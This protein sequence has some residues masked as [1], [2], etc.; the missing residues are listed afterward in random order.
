MNLDPE[1]QGL[2]AEGWQFWKKIGIRISDVKRVHSSILHAMHVGLPTPSVTDVQ[3]KMQ[4]LLGKTSAVTKISLEKVKDGG[5]PGALNRSYVYYRENTGIYRLQEIIK[6]LRRIAE[7]MGVALEHVDLTRLEQRWS[8]KRNNSGNACERM[9]RL[10]STDLSGSVRQFE[11]DKVILAIGNGLRAITAHGL[12]FDLKPPVNLFNEFTFFQIRKKYQNG[13]LRPR[14]QGFW[15]W[16]QQG[17]CP[18]MKGGP[19]VSKLGFVAMLENETEDA[20][21]MKVVSDSSY[22]HFAQDVRPAN[23]ERYRAMK[24]YFISQFMQISDEDIDHEDYKVCNYAVGPFV[25]GD[26]NVQVEMAAGHG[27]MVPG[28]ALKMVENLCLPEQGVCSKLWRKENELLDELA[29]IREGCHDY[30]SYGYSLFQDEHRASR[31]ASPA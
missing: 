31:G 23:L 20:Y 24:R 17:K 26:R 4:E 12:D 25:Q 22:A 3:R 9:M 7:N 16:G 15:A 8:K 27:F 2:I 5:F 21:V 19:D 11:G 14:P 13:S 30:P 28:L 1:S 10:T 18:W 29:H 6:D